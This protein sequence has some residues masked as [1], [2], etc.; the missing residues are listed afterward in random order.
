MLLVTHDQSEALALADRIGLLFDGRLRALDT[1]QRLYNRPPNRLAAEFLG[2]ANLLAAQIVP[3]SSG[4][5]TVR[6]S[7]GEQILRLRPPQLDGAGS[8]LWLCIRPHQLSLAPQ[9][10]EDGWPCSLT[11]IVLGCEWK[12]SHYRVTVDVE[13]QTVNLE[14][15]AASLPRAA[16]SVV[17]LWFSSEAAWLLPV[18]G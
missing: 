10:L 12:G 4:D 14:V 6:V 13:G 2:Q 8:R 17:T 3:H 18:E 15:S 16:G 11:G 7:V 9:G 5:G 1:P